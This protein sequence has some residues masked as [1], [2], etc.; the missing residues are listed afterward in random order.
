MFQDKN[1]KENRSTNGGGGRKF[2]P[3]F[4]RDG[5][6]TI[7]PGDIFDDLP[8]GETSSIWS[9][10]FDHHVGRGSFS[11][12]PERGFFRDILGDEIVESLPP[13]LGTT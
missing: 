5:T 11:P 9:K 10:L 4:G 7:L 3:V 8:P 1:G 6:K 2:V 13:I 12:I